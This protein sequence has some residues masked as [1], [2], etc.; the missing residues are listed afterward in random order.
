MVM[1]TADSMRDLTEKLQFRI[2]KL[3]DTAT[4]KKKTKTHS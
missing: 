1:H 4:R 2:E 3:E